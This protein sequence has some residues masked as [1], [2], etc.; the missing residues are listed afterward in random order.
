SHVEWAL[1]WVWNHPEVSVALSGM[2][3]M[4]QVIDN[5]K[6]ADHALPNILT[7]E[8]LSLF[9]RV[10]EFYRTRGFINCSGCRYCLP[11]PNGVLIPD[12]FAY[13]NEYFRRGRDSSVIDEYNSRI[14]N[15]GKA[16]NCVKCGRC[17]ELCPQHI[18]IR[19]WLDRARRLFMRP[20]R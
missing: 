6:Y 2:S 5:V 17:E 20:S 16:E 10:R 11:C 7:A 18:E 3:S 4:Q 19:V 12:I 9:D 13:Y 14:P 1:L 15:E 8:E